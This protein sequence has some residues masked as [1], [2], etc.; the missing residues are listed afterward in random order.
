MTCPSAWAGDDGFRIPTGAVGDLLI[1]SWPAPRVR[2]SFCCD[3]RRRYGVVPVPTVPRRYGARHISVRS[4]A[5][6]KR[7]LGATPWPTPRGAL[8]GGR[9]TQL[10]RLPHRDRVSGRGEPPMRLSTTC[11]MRTHQGRIAY[12]AGSLE[13]PKLIRL[14]IAFRICVTW[15]SFRPKS[16]KAVFGRE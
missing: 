4:R 1:L 7:P 16:T 8:W 10:R 9:G 2:A 5:P 14:S 3:I 12:I 13:S 6:T 15:R 11:Y